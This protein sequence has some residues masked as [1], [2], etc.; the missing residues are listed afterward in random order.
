[1]NIIINRVVF[2]LKICEHGLFLFK[3]LKI[4]QTSRTFQYFLV[5][6]VQWHLSVKFRV[7]GFIIH[8]YTFLY[9]LFE[10]QARLVLLG[11]FLHIEHGNKDIL[12]MK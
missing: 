8:K 4:W 9:I 1:M 2:I 5:I 11:I 7:L 12:V 6:C 3:Y 10:I